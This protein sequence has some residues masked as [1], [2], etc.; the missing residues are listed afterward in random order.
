VSLSINLIAWERDGYN[1]HILAVCE[2]VMEDGASSD[3]QAWHLARRRI[4]E[5]F[6]SC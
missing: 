3:L 6:N 5:F 2:A 4:R 1:F